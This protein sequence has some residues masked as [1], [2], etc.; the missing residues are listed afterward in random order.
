MKLNTADPETRLLIQRWIGAAQTGDLND[1]DTVNELLNDVVGL[2]QYLDAN[3]WVIE[4]G[5]EQVVVPNGRKIALCVGHSREGDKGA[6]SVGN[7]SEW[8][9]NSILARDLSDD[10][11]LKGYSPI[12]VDFYKGGSYT[13]AMNWLASFLKSEGVEMAIEFHFN[14]SDDESSNGF[15]YLYWHNSSNG[16]AMAQSFL[17]AHAEKFQWAKNRGIKPK[18]SGERGSQFLSKVHCPCIILEPFFGSNPEEWYNYSSQSGA[19][20]LLDVYIKG[21]DSYL[22]SH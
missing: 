3:G 12:V 10:L 18:S 19:N 20:K 9:F 7:K 11:Q 6:Y 21:I 22:T 17:A 1:P 15:E 5:D 13:A 4:H 16:K 2:K 14:S 8:D